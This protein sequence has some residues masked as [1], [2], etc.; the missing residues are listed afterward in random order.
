VDPLQWW[1]ALTKQFTELATTAIKDNAVDATKNLATS[2]VKQGFDATGQA[3]KKAAAV[4]A[5]VARKVGGPAT[6][7]AARARGTG[8]RA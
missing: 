4:P 5:G 8:S 3:L 7:T 2:M 6:K 1:G